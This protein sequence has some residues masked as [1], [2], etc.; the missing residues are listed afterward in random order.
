[1]KNIAIIPAR[2]GSKGLKDKNIKL[3]N[4]KP[5][6]YYSIKAALDSGCFDEVMVSTDSENYRQIAIE[7][8][9]SVPFLRSEKNSQD[10]SGSWD[11][12]I[13]CLENYK[14]LGKTFDNFMLLQPTSPL[15]TSQDIINSFE[16]MSTNNADAI[17]S[18]VEEDHNPLY[19]SVVPETLDLKE[20]YS[21]E[22]F[23]LPRQALPTFYRLNGAIY[24]C[25]INHFLSKGTLYHGKVL[26]YKMDK[27]SSVDIDCEFDFK[28]AELLYREYFEKNTDFTK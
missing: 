1:M 28:L 20:M 15:R 21:S 16:L 26:G 5:L 11:V 2:S 8:G 19:S 13:E 6:I 10:K 7:C 22:Y 17:L 18:I 25:N 4:G 27:N 9:A 12:V 3:L 24:L 14:K 23:D